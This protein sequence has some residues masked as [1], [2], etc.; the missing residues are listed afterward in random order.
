MGRELGGR[1]SPNVQL[2]LEHRVPI[3]L[4]HHTCFLLERLRPL[5][6]ADGKGAG[7]KGQGRPGLLGGFSKESARI[8]SRTSPR[9]PLTSHT[10]SPRSQGYSP[11]P[12]LGHCAVW[13]P[14]L[15]APCSHRRT[16]LPA[17]AGAAGKLE[18]SRR[19]AQKLSCQSQPAPFFHE[20]HAMYFHRP[21]PH[22]TAMLLKGFCL[23]VHICRCCE[24][25]S[26]GCISPHGAGSPERALTPVLVPS[27]GM[28]PGCVC[29]REASL[30][31]P[32]NPVAGLASGPLPTQASRSPGALVGM[33]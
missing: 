24:F 9:G 13:R 31:P 12:R 19:R 7:V 23:C 28:R 11:R 15:Q 17:A 26:R 32:P 25:C 14:G 22:S 16:G 30:S 33:W 3:C 5:L 6:S 29:V 4:L 10:S 21:S 2:W 20:A 18:A 1:D 8:T 27:V